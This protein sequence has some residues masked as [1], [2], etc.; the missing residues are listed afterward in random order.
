M[1]GKHAM[2]DRRPV[3]LA[4]AEERARAVPSLLSNGRAASSIIRRRFLTL[5][6]AA[7][8]VPGTSAAQQPPRRFGV[9]ARPGFQF[10]ALRDGLRALGWYDGSNLL[11]HH[12]SIGEGEAFAKLPVTFPESIFA[13]A[14]EVI[15]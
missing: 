3:A 2:L 8:A 13:R 9:M 10:E 1:I 15:E 6:R 7:A 5:S 11:L 12:V 14:D 4:A